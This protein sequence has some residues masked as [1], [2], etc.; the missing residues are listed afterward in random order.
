MAKNRFSLLTA[1]R[2]WAQGDACALFYLN[3]AALRSFVLHLDG[4]IGRGTVAD[5]DHVSFVPLGPELRGI[6]LDDEVVLSIRHQGV[7]SRIKSSSGT[8]A[9]TEDTFD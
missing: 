4:D 3:D 2:A 1:A 6:A 5:D 8:G 7:I 9:V